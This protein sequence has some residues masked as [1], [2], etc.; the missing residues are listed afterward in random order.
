M[1]LA[2]HRSTEFTA[3]DDERIFQQSAL[4]LYATERT[5][6]ALIDKFEY[7]FGAYGREGCPALDWREVEWYEPFDVLGVSVVPLPVMH[8]SMEVMALRFKNWA[9]VVDVSKIPADSMA[10]LEG[11]DVLVL[12][13]E[14]GRIK[15]TMK[16]L[17]EAETAEA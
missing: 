7:C 17:P 5:G 4:P 1:A 6:R 14:R 16:D 11:L 2:E 3:P 13:V 12:D 9:Y 15:L 8:G 10:Q